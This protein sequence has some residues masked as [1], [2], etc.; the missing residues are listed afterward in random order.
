MSFFSFIKNNEFNLWL[1]CTLPFP[2][3]GGGGGVDP[4]DGLQETIRQVLE[5]P[6]VDFEVHCLVEMT[7]GF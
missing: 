3:F 7:N 6:V 2:F 1:C 5:I 4:K